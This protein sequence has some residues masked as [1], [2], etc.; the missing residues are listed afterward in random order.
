MTENKICRCCTPID[1]IIDT[2]SILIDLI[3]IEMYQLK[4]TSR[5]LKYCYDNMVV[6]NDWYAY[7][8]IRSKLDLLN[9]YTPEDTPLYLECRQL[10]NQYSKSF[11]LLT[12]LPLQYVN[13]AKRRLFSEQDSFKIFKK[14]LVSN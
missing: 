10:S 5:Y 12:Q 8:L 1:S 14:N 9:S 13:Y 4:H 11:R 6:F 3:E 2:L 7:Q